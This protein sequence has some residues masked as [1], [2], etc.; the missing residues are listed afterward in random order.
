MQTHRKHLETL[1][2]SQNV[3]FSPL[4]AWQLSCAV[5][6]LSSPVKFSRRRRGGASS[7]SQDT[8]KPQLGTCPSLSA[9]LFSCQEEFPVFKAGEC[10]LK[11]RPELTRKAFLEIS[12]F[13]AWSVK[14][15]V[16]QSYEMFRLFFATPKR[17]CFTMLMVWKGRCSPSRHNYQGNIPAPETTWKN[18]QI[19]NS[20]K[21]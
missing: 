4:C 11:S 3:F 16:L 5:F 7:M 1:N 12:R 6:L 18:T 13:I 2:D 17:E 15:L 14:L 19:T 9:R 20:D 8:L 10:I 21:D